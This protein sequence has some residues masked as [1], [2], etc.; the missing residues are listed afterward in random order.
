VTRPALT[1]LALVAA[2]TAGPATAR[3]APDEPVVVTGR[4]LAPLLGRRIGSLGLLVWRGGAWHP[5]PFQVDP[6][7]LLRRPGRATRLVHLLRA[8][9][10]PDPVPSR[11][12]GPEDEL[13]FMREDAG[14]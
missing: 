4:A 2:I 1:A 10:E 12:L 6:R 9:G 7:V 14:A 11:P 13:V 8:P 3:A 5:I